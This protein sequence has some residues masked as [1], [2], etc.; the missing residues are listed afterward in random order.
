[1]SLSTL[2]ILVLFPYA[3]TAT[4]VVTDPYRDL[5]YDKIAVY[6]FTEDEERHYDTINVHCH[7]DCTYPDDSKPAV[8]YTPLIFYPLVDTDYY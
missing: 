2:L 1:M 5:V 7:D 8:N 6:D 4:I 3:C